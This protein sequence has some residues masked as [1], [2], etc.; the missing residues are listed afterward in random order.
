MLGL[1][2]TEA[3]V[4]EK[5]II[6]VQSTAVDS[7]DGLTVEILEF[8]GSGIAA[9]ARQ[10]DDDVAINTSH[11][12]LKQIFLTIG[13]NDLRYKSRYNTIIPV[14]LHFCYR[15]NFSSVA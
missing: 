2:S 9:S 10:T 11:T 14:K 8:G 13:Q 4:A 6:P 15:L 7:F 12:T 1:T 5:A 3:W